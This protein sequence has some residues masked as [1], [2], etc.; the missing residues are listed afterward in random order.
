MPSQSR[1]AWVGH[2]NEV[3]MA[4]YIRD[5]YLYSQMLD[6]GPVATIYPS[7]SSSSL[8]HRPVA[9]SL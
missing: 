8:H 5:L 6:T 3:C 2:Y 4:K 7:L 9:A 1:Q